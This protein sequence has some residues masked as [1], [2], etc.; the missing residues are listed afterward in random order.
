MMMNRTIAADHGEDRQAGRPQEV[1]HGDDPVDEVGDVLHPLDGRIGAQAVHDRAEVGRVAEL[2]LQAGVEG[3]R[4]EVAGEVLLAL[5][6]ARLAEAAEGLLLRDEGDL[7]N[8]GQG[9]DPGLHVGDVGLRRGGPEVGHHLDLLLHEGEP[10]EQP[11][12]TIQKPASSSSIRVIVAVAARLIA[13]LRQKPC[14]ARDTLKARNP[15]M[16]AG[17]GGSRRPAAPV[18]EPGLSHAGGTRHRSRR[19]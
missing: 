14:Q 8:L 13:A 10:R 19:G 5:G 1:G 12:W 17:P 18:G 3:V 6:R 9:R 2:D 16:A 7:A 15:I 4:V 11:V